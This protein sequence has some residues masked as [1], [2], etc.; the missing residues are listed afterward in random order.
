MN[1][2]KKKQLS[3]I[4]LVFWISFSG[5]LAQ[6]LSI[7]WDKGAFETGKYRN[8]LAEC[9]YSEQ[10][11]DDKING[12]FDGLFK[13][14]NKIYFEAEDSLAYI[15]DIKNHDV[16]TEGMSY[17]MMIAV[18]F[19]RKDIFDRLWRWSKKYMQHQSGAL[20]GYFAWSCKIN[21][22]R[23]AQG[24]ASDGELYYITAL[25]FAS[26]LWGN[27]S[28]IDYLKEAQ[29]ILDCMM[30]KDGTDGV[31]NIINM[32]H[33]L[34]TFVPDIRGERFTDPSYHI[35]AF[36]EVWASWAKDG[37]AGLWRE[38]AVKSREYLHR[39]VH[40]VTG[41]TPDYSNYDGSLLGNGRVIGDAF[42]FDSWRVP[43]NIA[44]DYSW[45]CVDKEWQREY[46]NK[47]QNFL[48]QQGTD[49]FPDQYNVDGTTVK[50][51]LQAGGY[52]ALR[53]SLG[54]VASAAAISITAT[55][56]I[57]KEFINELWNAQ[58]KPYSDGYFDA[59]Y[60]GLLHLFSF[61]H[62]SGRYRVILPE[63]KDQNENP[64]WVGTWS[65]APQLV[66]PGNMP[67]SPGLSDNILRQIVRVS[68]GGEKV[69]LRFS[70]GFG[71]Q[72]VTM[73]SG[74]IALAKED[75]KIDVSSEQ[76]LTFQG[77]DSVTI[78]PY[79]EI[80][81]D[82]VP[83]HFDNNA[84]AAITIYFGKTSPT[85]TGHPGSRTTSYLFS[86][87]NSMSSLTDTLRIEHWYIIQG[88]DVQATQETAV[89]AVLGNSVTDG[90][91]SGTDKQNRWTDILSERLLDDRSF[92]RD[93]GVL[94]LGIGGNCVVRGGLGPTALERFDRD[95][96][97]Q[98]GV[99]WLIILEGIN[100]IGGI[101]TGETVS[102]CIQELTDAYTQMID[103]AH[104]KGIKVYGC[105]ILPFAKSF[106]DTPFRREAWKKVNDWIRK[107]G[108]F[109]SVI[110][111]A[112]IMRSPGNS[113]IIMEG[114]HSGDFLH[115]N[116]A[117]Y[118]R[119]G[120]AVDLSLFSD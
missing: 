1:N 26:N 93:R 10:A 45:A 74:A 42:R 6:E 34:I 71:N 101:R 80:Y 86:G 106:Y 94:N 87:N 118:K 23:N 17:G 19:G 16:R 103:K 89:V 40:P 112:E 62:L 20:E 37:R 76:K 49:R 46:G 99:K 21:G 29:Y 41:L 43:M 22:I 52:K 50:D 114:M 115:P 95:I 77:K 81:S 68:I 18:Q 75:G 35:P 30:K 8:L 107:S 64:K 31:T 92:T 97:S 65:A 39:V 57:R 120:E 90:R 38:C 79:E 109:D 47:I 59:Y 78:P 5:L 88:I 108:K 69:R 53:H 113:D 63:G 48:C 4:V 11:I 85:L 58:H 3:V 28:G 32:N 7:P 36:Y 24:P 83:F 60:D 2:I 27:D 33:K 100:D 13:G 102:E 119:M 84:R 66:E 116:E 15:S 111:F 9:G 110:D 96:L 44:L 67:P 56:G 117:G 12:I 54:L 70:N 98:S 104:S 25:I 105:T 91:G 82:P 14:E 61:M 55:H 73:K 51:T 72:P